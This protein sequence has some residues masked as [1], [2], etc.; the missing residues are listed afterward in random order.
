LL[1]YRNTMVSTDFESF[2]C[3]C[4]FCLYFYLYKSKFKVFFRKKTIKENWWQ[5]PWPS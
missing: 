2:Y 4:I 5:N 3:F 1:W